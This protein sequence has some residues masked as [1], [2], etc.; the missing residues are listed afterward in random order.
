MK[1][2]SKQRSCYEKSFF[3]FYQYADDDMQRAS[4]SQ[5]LYTYISYPSYFTKFQGYIFFK[6][7]TDNI[8]IFSVSFNII[9]NQ[10]I[11]E[12]VF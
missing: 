11:S 12:K 8:L 5:N 7:M 9:M 1:R 3:F 10:M 4:K 6:N 2:Y